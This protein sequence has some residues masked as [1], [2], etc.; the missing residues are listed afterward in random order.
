MSL[1]EK[2]KKQR[3]VTLAA[4]IAAL[5]TVLTLISFAMGLDKGV[6]QLRLSEALAVLPAFT[7]AAI[8]GLF[9]GCMLSS[10]LTGGHPLDALFGSLVTLLAALLCYM[11]RAC[12]RKRAGLL[13]LPLP[14]ILLNALLIPFVLILAYGAGEAYPYMVLTVGIGE[15]ISSGVL[16]VLLAISMRKH[17]L[18]KH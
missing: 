8:P 17:D 14:N 18:L 12:A 9:A 4:I 7:S 6:I 5:Y 13:L 3:Y 10:F 16:G 11:M 15:L 1:F 2:S